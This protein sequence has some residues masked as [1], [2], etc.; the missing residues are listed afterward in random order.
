MYNKEISMIKCLLMFLI[1][2]SAFAIP[3]NSKDIVVNYD[4][5]GVVRGKMRLG[6]SSYLGKRINKEGYMK[7]LNLYIDSPGG[8]VVNTLFIVDLLEDLKSEGVEITCVVKRAES[9]AFTILQACNNKYALTYATLMNHRC[10][11]AGWFCNVTD[12]LRYT[13][14]TKGKKITKEKWEALTSV[15]YYLSLEE[16]YKYR[17]INEVFKGRLIY[18]TY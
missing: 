16:A 10:S 18:E 9:G 13:Y 14:E 17:F 7:K 4:L 8:E 3:E 6:L 12:K 1:S 5:V 2:F 15:D 11:P